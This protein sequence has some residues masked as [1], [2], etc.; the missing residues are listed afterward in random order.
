MGRKVVLAL[1]G[2]TVAAFT[3]IGWYYHT[4]KKIKFNLDDAFDGGWYHDFE[5]V[6]RREEGIDKK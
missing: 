3:A 5:S 1:S 4:T 2:L 6:K